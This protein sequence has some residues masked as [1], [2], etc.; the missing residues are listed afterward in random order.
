MEEL[1]A[2]RLSAYRNLVYETPGFEKYF[3]EATVITEIAELNIGSRPASRKKGRIEDLR[4]IPWVFS[5]SQCAAHAAGLVR[6]RFGGRRISRP[7]RR[8]H[9]DVCRPC[10]ASGPSSATLIS[11]MDMVLSKTDIAIASALR[12]S[13]RGRGAARAHLPAHQG[14]MAGARRRPVRH[15]RPAE[16]LSTEPAARALDPQPLS[17]HR[18]A[19]PR[20]DRVA[21]PLARRRDRDE[22]VVPGI[23][24]TINGIA[25]GLRN[26]G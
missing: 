11:N 15:H 24:L 5:W 19:E 10:I 14:R 21:A 16:L 25:A 23:H 2:L 20:A 17:L 18:P 3:R 12:R 4:A 9:G 1:S 6:L 13:G 8:R 7:A 26:S 22:R